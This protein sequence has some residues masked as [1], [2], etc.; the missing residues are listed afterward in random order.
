MSSFQLT[1]DLAREESAND[2][3]LL[4]CKRNRRKMAPYN[5]FFVSN[6]MVNILSSVVHAANIEIQF[7][8]MY[9]SE[10]AGFTPDPVNRCQVSGVWP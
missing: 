9:H 7:K 3:V 1:V 2:I 10:D 4:H 8:Q 5:K 6:L